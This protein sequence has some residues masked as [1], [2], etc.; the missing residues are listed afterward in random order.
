MSLCSSAT[1]P[2]APSTATR[3]APGAALGAAHSARAPSIRRPSTAT[4]P[5]R[6]VIC[7]PN[8]SRYAPDAAGK[9]PSSATAP[10][11]SAGTNAGDRRRATAAPAATAD[12][13]AS[14]R[15][16]AA[17]AATRVGESGIPR[18]PK[19][20][21]SS[22]DASERRASSERASSERAS[23][24][25]A[26]STTRT[27]VPAP[28]P[29]KLPLASGSGPYT[30]TPRRGADAGE[31]HLISS[32]SIARP[33]TGP[34]VPKR[35]D[36]LAP[37][38]TRDR[39]TDWKKTL[40]SAPPSAGSVRGATRVAAAPPRGETAAV[41]AVDHPRAGEPASTCAASAPAHAGA[42]GR[43]HA[44]SAEDT[45][46]PG[47]ANA[48]LPE[49]AFFSPSPASAS[50][51]ATPKR[52]RQNA[53]VDARSTP[54]TN[55]G[56]PPTAGPSH[57]TA[58][59]ATG[60]GAFAGDVSSAETAA[61]RNSAVR[62]A[63][64]AA[65]AVSA[66]SRR[67]SLSSGRYATTAS[68]ATPP[69]FQTS[70]KTPC[71]RQFSSLATS[72]TAPSPGVRA[73]V[74]HA[75]SADET[76]R[77]ATIRA[78]RGSNAHAS[79]TCRSPPVIHTTSPPDASID[80]GAT[81]VGRGVTSY[82]KVSAPRGGDAAAPAPPPPRIA[83]PTLTNPPAWFANG[84]ATHSIS[85]PCSFIDTG[86]TTRGPNWHAS[87]S[88]KPAPCTATR[89]PPVTNPRSGASARTATAPSATAPSTSSGLSARVADVSVSNAH[90]RNASECVERRSRARRPRRDPRA[91][92]SNRSNRNARQ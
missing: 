4:D 85:V 16:S 1:A 52:N 51:A 46:A 71:P 78:G 90:S 19:R 3:F 28:V 58:D 57:G 67:I 22:D 63:A 77:F 6:H 8:A 66:P 60:T 33:A 92:D 36:A 76:N 54:A 44:I 89:R 15:A 30:R 37:T 45:T 24:A 65:D 14:S 86:A 20:A 43:S 62:R 49:E 12:A 83:T 82:A 80:R 35:H 13:S 68:P 79:A 56:E 73:G 27:V 50:A 88:V 87:A 23:R 84:G 74:S 61:A 38:E 21:V 10:P 2:A 34:I 47:T 40:T 29:K 70:F 81:L 72:A 18:R 5:K 39:E 48:G 25:L 7:V 26:S 42:G 53:G 9:T 75:P 31:T 69:S 11:N 55:T 64:R 41:P 91:R 17:T 59:T 32:A